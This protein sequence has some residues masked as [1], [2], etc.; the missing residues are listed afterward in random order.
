MN[1]LGIHALVWTG[2]WGEAESEMAIAATAEL[3]YDLI[4]IPLLDPAKVDAAR[5]R[6][7]LEAHGVAAKTSLGLHF[8]AD[9]SS[10]DPEIAARGEA[11]LGDALA[12][13]RD[14]GADFMGGVIYSALGKY[15]APPT[16]AGRAHCVEALARLAA[17][18]KESG[19]TLGLEPVNRYESNLINTGAQAL[20]I[21][22]A[23]GADNIVVHL[24]SYHMNIEEGDLARAVETCAAKLG[25]VHIR[26]S[27]RGYLGTGTIDFRTLFTALARVGYTGAITFESFSSAVVDEQLSTALAVW[28]NLWSDGKDLA[29]EAKRFIE[30]ELTA[31]EMA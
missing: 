24:D 5:T 2:G 6:R 30:A 14:I 1:K 20:E 8:E 27:H 9:I 31:V 15:P 18:A 25:Y 26:E 7:Q 11:L 19:I 4:E 17:R 3:G 23:T 22:E 21:I 29:R 28:R 12:A 10:P 13:T 16:P